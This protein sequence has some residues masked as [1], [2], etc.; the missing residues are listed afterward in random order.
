MVLCCL[1]IQPMA[2]RQCVPSRH[3][4]QDHSGDCWCGQAARQPV[5]ACWL[6]G[7]RLKAS[8]IL[9][10]ACLA[11]PVTFSARPLVLSRRLPVTRPVLFLV[12]PLAGLGLVPDLLEN[13][14]GCF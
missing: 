3:A 10:L 1:V 14:H 6:S 7:Q 11:S 2:E 12:I 4:P 9:S 5:G 8:L 13:A